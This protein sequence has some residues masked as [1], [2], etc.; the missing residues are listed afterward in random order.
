[1]KKFMEDINWWELV[2]D[3]DAVVWDNAPVGLA[4]P[5]QKRN[6]DSSTII[7]YVPSNTY[8]YSGVAKLRPDSSY[9]AKWYNTRMGE[10]TLISSNIKTDRSGTWTIP[11]APDY[12][13][14][15]LVITL[16]AIN[17]EAFKAISFDRISVDQPYNVTNKLNYIYKTA[18][19]AD[20]TWESSNNNVVDS[21]SGEVKQTD[22]EEKVR[23]VA[24]ITTNKGTDYKG[25]TLTIPAK[26]SDDEQTGNDE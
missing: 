18:D 20:V 6:E 9:T 8:S 14:W 2:P 13:D 23:L 3:K 19:G 16:N 10:Y 17:T 4:S 22:K 1:M 15:A 24:K 26:E 25:F 5:F 7:A 11:S 21:K 12:S